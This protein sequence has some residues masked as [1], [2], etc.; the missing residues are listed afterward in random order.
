MAD[1]FVSLRA[2]FREGSHLRLDAAVYA[3]TYLDVH[4]FDQNALSLGAVY[5]WTFGAWRTEAGLYAGYGTL[6]GDAFDQ[7]GGGSNRTGSFWGSSNTRTITPAT[8]S[9]PISGRYSRSEC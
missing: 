4:D 2:P 8:R 6:G 7:T 5:D 3:L 1:A 9:F